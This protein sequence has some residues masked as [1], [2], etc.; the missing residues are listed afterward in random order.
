METFRWRLQGEVGFSY[1]H[2]WESYPKA[3][4]VEK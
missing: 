3:H 4:Q 2:L 1:L